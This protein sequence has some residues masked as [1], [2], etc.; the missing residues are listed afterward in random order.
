[1]K[2]A[3]PIDE[4]LAAAD[5]L[6]GR[7]LRPELDAGWAR[8]RAQSPTGAR[9]S[10]SRRRG[11]LTVATLALAGG[12]AVAL[13]LLPDL[14]ARDGSG[15][16][17]GGVLPDGP[18]AAFAATLERPGILH[19]VTET[20]ER[21]GDDGTR[22]S[23]PTVR[24]ELFYAVDGS[25]WRQRMTVSSHDVSSESTFD[26]TELRTYNTAQGLLQ[27]IPVPER[28]DPDGPQ[29]TRPFAARTLDLAE[30]LAAGDYQELGAAVVRGEPAVVIGRDVH[31][32]DAYPIDQ[33]L[34]V[35]RDRSTL[36]RVDSLELPMPKDASRDD[37][38][39]QRD[40]VLTFEILPSTP[41]LR[42]RL[43]ASKE[44]RGDET[45]FDYGDPAPDMTPL[46]R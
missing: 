2:P 37:W 41:E 32:T 31:P 7:D 24:D 27:R 35:S 19:A 38:R 33:R 4:C 6:R 10:T 18:V 26:G 40:E 29:D 8:V 11:W 17:A 22:D 5:P 21:V 14:S 28:P 20:S 25:R 16:R 42:D 12:I 15:G 23:E 45:V 34:F 9:R 36:L 43:L 46:R 3:D 1:M 44:L 39:W 30:R 13:A